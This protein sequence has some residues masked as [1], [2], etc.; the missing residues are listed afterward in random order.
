MLKGNQARAVNLPILGLVLLTFVLYAP[1]CSPKDVVSE[2]EIRAA[3]RNLGSHSSE[4]PF[5]VFYKNPE[6]AT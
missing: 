6:V 1:P 5:E 2:K 4:D 3:V